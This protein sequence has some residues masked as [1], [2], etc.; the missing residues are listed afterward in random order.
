MSNSS[1]EAPP[2]IASSSP[3]PTYSSNFTKTIVGCLELHFLY[4]HNQSCS[5]L[6]SH[7]GMCWVPNISN[8]KTAWCPTLSQFPCHERKNLLGL[9]SKLATATWEITRRLA[10]VQEGSE[11]KRRLAP[12]ADKAMWDDSSTALIILESAQTQIPSLS[13]SPLLKGVTKL[14]NLTPTLQ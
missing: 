1:P 4:T 5:C 12:A 3:V 13:Q 10:P 9:S 7:K 2:S 14:Q 8:L 6:N 11:L